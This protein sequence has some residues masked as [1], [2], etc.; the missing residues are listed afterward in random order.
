MVDVVGAAVVGEAALLLRAG[1]RVVRTVGL[2]DVVLNEW[3]SG[4]T[5]DGEVTVD[6]KVVPR[7][8]VADGA[9]RPGV[10]PFSTDKVVAVLPVHAVRTGSRVLLVGHGLSAPSL[11]HVGKSLT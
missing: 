11:G 4:P 5:V 1:G 6:T 7:A 9:S 10:P 8:V 2:D 3:V